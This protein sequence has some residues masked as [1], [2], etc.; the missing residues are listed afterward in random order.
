[1]INILGIAFSILKQIIHPLIHL[2]SAVLFT[3]LV[4][5]PETCDGDFQ[6]H[7]VG[8]LPTFLLQCRVQVPL[9]FSRSNELQVVLVVS[10]YHRLLS[11]GTII[12]FLMFLNKL[13]FYQ[14]FNKYS[15]KSLHISFIASSNYR[16]YNL[17]R[18]RTNY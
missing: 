2:Q 11:S 6:K 1:V 18:N 3:F 13:L 5:F 4:D 16:S 10:F 17:R 12:N 7:F 14:S 8:G 15:Q 9:I